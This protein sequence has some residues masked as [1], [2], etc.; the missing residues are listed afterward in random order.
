MKRI[1]QQDFDVLFLTKIVKLL[2]LAAGNSG[3]FSNDSAD[4]LQNCAIFHMSQ[5]IINLLLAQD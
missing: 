3:L 1:K 4:K 2:K 5:H